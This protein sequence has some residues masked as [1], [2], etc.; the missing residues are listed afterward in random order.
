LVEKDYKPIIS[1]S[2]PLQ[3]LYAK[4]KTCC[5]NDGYR[6]CSLRTFS[7]RLQAKGYEVKKGHGARKIFIEKMLESAQDVDNDCINETG[8]PF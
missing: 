8:A 2:M 4:Y 7:D 6:V 1:E 5:D 3:E